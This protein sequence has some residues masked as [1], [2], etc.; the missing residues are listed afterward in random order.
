MCDTLDPRVTALGAAMTA[1]LVRPLVTGAVDLLPHVAEAEERDA[2]N[3]AIWNCKA[4]KIAVF[5]VMSG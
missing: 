4:E 5:E 1:R 2:T 3:E